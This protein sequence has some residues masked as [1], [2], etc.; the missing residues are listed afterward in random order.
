MQDYFWITMKLCSLMSQHG[1]IS[2]YLFD[3][4]I[5]NVNLC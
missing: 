4:I 3:F 5:E 2:I 1:K